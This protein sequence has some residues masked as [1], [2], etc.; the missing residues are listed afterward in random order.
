MT[1]HQD[2]TPPAKGSQE[3]RDA[4]LAAAKKECNA[5]NAAALNEALKVTNARVDALTNRLEHCERQLVQAMRTI[6]RLEITNN[7]LRAKLTG[8]GATS[9]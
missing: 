2:P 5:K 8:H 6:Q 1:D 9:E 4:R 3:E 7:V